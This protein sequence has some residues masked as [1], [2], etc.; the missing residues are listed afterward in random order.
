MFRKIALWSVLPIIA[1]TAIA[2]TSTNE[3]I[4]VRAGMFQDSAEKVVRPAPDLSLHD[5]LPIYRKSVV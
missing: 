2:F 3:F 4:P 5:A 1:A